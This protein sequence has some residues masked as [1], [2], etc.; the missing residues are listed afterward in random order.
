MDEIQS[1]L[2]KNKGKQLSHGYKRYF[3]ENSSFLGD[4]V[5]GAG[6]YNPHDS[7]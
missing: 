3:H 6:N 4:K 1:L 5:P 7:V 2:E